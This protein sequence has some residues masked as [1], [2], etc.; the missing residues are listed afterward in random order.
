MNKLANCLAKSKT[1]LP[2]ADYLPCFAQEIIAK[3]LCDDNSNTIFYLSQK[4]LLAALSEK[5]LI[6]A[7]R[8][9]QAIFFLWPKWVKFG[10]ESVKL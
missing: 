10:L 4:N 5:D 3:L 9:N 1:L 7:P 8:Q 2:A 6:R